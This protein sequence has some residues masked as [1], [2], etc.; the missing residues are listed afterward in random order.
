[1][2]LNWK[3]RG[4]DYSSYYRGA[5]E[6]D[7]SLT[8]LADTGANATE[9]TL[10]WGI[11]P[12]TNTVYADSQYTDP[13]TAEAAVIREA[14][15]KGLQVMVKPHLDFLNAADLQGTPY[16]VSDWRTYY[17]PGAAGSTGANSFFASYKTMLLQ[18]AAVAVANG[19]TMLCIGTELDQIAGP[20]YKSYWDGIISTLRRQDPTL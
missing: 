5:Y 7:D 6:N 1:M 15:A 19:A 17:N 12:L 14:V 20:A 11:D 16:S 2:A 8:A 4:F 18:E 3:L 9:T 10:D 13:L